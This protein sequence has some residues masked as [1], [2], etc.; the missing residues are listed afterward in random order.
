[1]SMMDQFYTK[2]SNDLEKKNPRPLNLSKWK[3]R[4]IKK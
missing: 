2:M 4:C 3:F 1:M